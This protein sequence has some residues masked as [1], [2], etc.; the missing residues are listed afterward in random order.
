LNSGGGDL[1]D[2]MPSGSLKSNPKKVTEQ[3]LAWMLERL[4]G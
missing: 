1:A 3:D 4:T 2:S